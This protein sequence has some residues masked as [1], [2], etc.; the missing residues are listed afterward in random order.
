MLDKNNLPSHIA[1]IMDGNGR[2]AKKR[3]LPRIMGHRGGIKSIKKVVIRAN[4]IG[5]KFITVYAFSTENWKRS[6]DEVSGIFDLLVEFTL[7]ERAELHEKNVKV[8][9]LGK[10]EGIPKAAEKAIRDTMELTKNNSGLV[11]N[12]AVNYGSRDELT[13]AARVIARQVKDNLIS[14]EDI[15][16]ETI[17]RNLYTGVYNIPDPDLIVRTSGEQRLSNYLLW[18][19]AYSEFVFT[20][21]LWPDYDGDELE[22]SIEEY[23]K[24]NRRFGERKE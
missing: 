6:N 23:Q 8:I 11:L 13:M 17:S 18:Q 3:F 9:M 7:K 19:I 16:E 5:I 22:K 4:E 20:D 1:L 14:L 24:R 10:F 12:L 2:W 15:N 21:V